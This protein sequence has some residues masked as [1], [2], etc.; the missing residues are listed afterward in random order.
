MYQFEENPVSVN[1]LRR[2]VSKLLAVE[3]NFHVIP[4]LK[5]LTESIDALTLHGH[6]SA[7]R[8]C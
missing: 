4:H 1:L 7:L 3:E 5:A 8:M 2:L 6:G